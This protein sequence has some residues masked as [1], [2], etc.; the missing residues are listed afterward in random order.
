MNDRHGQASENKDNKDN[1]GL[2]LCCRKRTFLA[3]HAEMM[4]TLW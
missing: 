1:V 2:V 3:P 4:L